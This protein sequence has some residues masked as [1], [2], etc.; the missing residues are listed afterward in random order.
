M[1]YQNMTVIYSWLCLPKT[2]YQLAS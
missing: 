2:A 1:T